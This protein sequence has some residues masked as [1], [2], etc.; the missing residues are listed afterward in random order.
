MIDDFLPSQGIVARLFYSKKINKSE[1]G[2]LF[3]RLSELDVFILDPLRGNQI[4]PDLFYQEHSSDSFY[5]LSFNSCSIILIVIPPSNA[6][7]FRLDLNDYNLSAN[8]K[9][10][11]IF[12]NL[13]DDL[14]KSFDFKY[15]HIDLEGGLPSE[16]IEDI[17]N[18][19]I[20][21][22]FWINYFGKEYV[23]KYGKDFLLHVLDFNAFELPNGMVKCLTRATLDSAILP[24]I[25][26]NTNTCLDIKNEIKIYSAQDFDLPFS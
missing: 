10:I 21:W 23:E 16:I 5:F 17:E 15:A 11:E 22:L 26:R 6:L 20:S 9:I 25:V 1:I 12:N 13:I 7:H 14:L 2:R 8:T 3:N 4:E 24:E 19:K 18:T